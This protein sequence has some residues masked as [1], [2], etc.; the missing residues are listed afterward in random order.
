MKLSLKTRI[1]A[2]IIAIASIATVVSASS[3][4][5]VFAEEGTKYVKSVYVTLTDEITVNYKAIIPAGTTKAEMTFYYR[6]REFTETLERAQAGEHIFRFTE[7]SPQYMAEK[8]SYKLSLY[9]ETNVEEVCAVDNEFSLKTYAE[10]LL[11]K[12]AYDL[13]QTADEN[14]KMRTLLV[15]LLFYG[16]AAAEYRGEGADPTT[17]LSEEVKALKSAFT[18]VENTDK[19]IEITGENPFKTVGLYFANKLGVYYTFAIDKAETD[20]LVLKINKG[21][22]VTEINDFTVDENGVFTGIY[23]DITLL[24]FDVPVIAE[25]FKNGVS[26]GTKLTYSVKSNVYAFQSDTKDEAFKTLVQAV[27][28][29]S[30]IASDY[31]TATETP[32]SYEVETKNCMVWYEST[33]FSPSGKGGYVNCIIDSTKNP[34]AVKEEDKTWTVNNWPSDEYVGSIPENGYITFCINSEI[35]GFAEVTLVASSA[36]VEKHNNWV[37][38]ETKVIDLSSAYTLTYGAYINYDRKD[39]KIYKGVSVGGD[40]T[41]NENGNYALWVAWH[42]V[43]LGK[44]Y[45][46]RGANFIKLTRNQGGGTGINVK[47]ATFKITD[48]K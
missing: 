43:T 35:E 25:L 15:D 42:T 20:E 46:Y 13:N 33:A 17:G 16:K 4:Q 36:E 40:K 7:L 12:S 21:E 23:E 30:R 41:N 45:L 18:Q 3:K 38:I 39:G 22:E 26:C 2:L 6:D 9:G 47:S 24:E 10:T 11:S 29:C 19:K 8:V 48:R 37:P 14:L 28:N 31:K 44:V 32:V 27:Y 1:F 34:N 5:G